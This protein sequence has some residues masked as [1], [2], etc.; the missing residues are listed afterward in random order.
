MRCRDLL[1]G[2]SRA[3]LPRVAKSDKAILLLVRTAAYERCGF[4]HYPQPSRPQN[5][6]IVTPNNDTPYS[7]CWLDLRAE[8]WLQRRTGQALWVW[9]RALRMSA[10]ACSMSTRACRVRTVS[11]GTPRSLAAWW[12]L[13]CSLVE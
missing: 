6:D 1:V 7:W 5:T 12:T 11:W 8:P 3:C 2:R 4:R 10:V 9:N 13:R